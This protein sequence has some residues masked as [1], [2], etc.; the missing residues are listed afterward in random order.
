MHITDEF[1]FCSQQY[2][3]FRPT[4]PESLFKWLYQ[5][6]NKHNLALDCGMGNGQATIQLAKYFKNVIGIDSNKNQIQEAT[7]HPKVTYKMMPAESIDLADSS[8]DLIVAASAVHWFDLEAFYTECKRLLTPKGKIVVWT[9]TWPETD[10][11]I[12]ANILSQIK[13]LLDPHW[14]KESL[15]HLNKYADLFFPFDNIQ[16]PC[17]QFAQEW[18]P[19]QLVNFFSTWACIRHYTKKVNNQ[20]FDFIK[21][22]I[23]KKFP[24]DMKVNFQFPLYLKAGEL[25]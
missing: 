10:N 14:S 21:D 13:Q 16:S 8:V 7:P 17:F 2:N 12:V 18:T 6:S 24:T 19:E 1:N 23:E 4:Y 22:L 25:N 20:F 3:K 11:T 15:L 9:Y 5:I